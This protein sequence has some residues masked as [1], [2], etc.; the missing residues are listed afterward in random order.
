[1]L[2]KSLT[3]QKTYSIIHPIQEEGERHANKEVRVKSS[4]NVHV[5]VNSAKKRACSYLVIIY[6]LK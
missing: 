3:D 5:H 2:Q 6:F 1:M 4:K